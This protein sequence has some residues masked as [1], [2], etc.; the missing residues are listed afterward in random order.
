MTFNYQKQQHFLSDKIPFQISFHK[1][2]N[3]ILH[4]HEF[5]ELVIVLGGSGFHE[6]KAI[7][8][9]ISTGDVFLIKQ[10]EQ[11]IYTEMKNLNIVNILFD[12]NSLNIDW[13]KFRNIHGFTALFET[14]P[15]LRERNNFA[16][17]HTLSP[18]QLEEISA[19]LYKL[20][21]EFDEKISGWEI[22]CFNLLQEIF[23]ML[24]RSYFNTRKKNS[25]QML[26]LSRMTQIIENN[27]SRDI[28]R[29]MIMHAGNTSNAVGTRIFKKLIGKS[30]IEYLTHIRLN[31][32]V[33]M[34]K[35]T[36]MNICDI[37]F[38]CGFHD[39]NYF[40]SQFKKN[41]G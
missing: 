19:I 29:D 37:A 41:M 13:E 7:K 10:G 20:K 1:Q 16:N 14:E 8:S 6:I 3:K 28:T 23:I 12:R 35:N 11:H 36:D 33:D 4:S 2:E 15:N 17:K 21:N 32:A 18:E 34:L 27:Y 26:C 22:M 30:P 38:K 5:D 25:Q 9:A 31:H 40:S 24:A 39:S